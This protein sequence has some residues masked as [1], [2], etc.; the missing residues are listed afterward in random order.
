MS[1]DNFPVIT[2]ITECNQILLTTKDLKDNLLIVEKIEAIHKLTLLTI[3]L[4]KEQKA[5]GIKTNG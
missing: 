4:K 1:T 2:T 5:G 3:L